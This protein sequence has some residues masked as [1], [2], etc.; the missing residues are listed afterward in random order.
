[1]VEYFEIPAPFPCSVALFV[2][3]CGATAVDYD[4]TEPAPTGWSVAEDGSARCPR[5]YARSPT[6]HATP[7]PPMPQ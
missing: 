1:M 7:V 5:C 3:G 4:V 2:C 6:G